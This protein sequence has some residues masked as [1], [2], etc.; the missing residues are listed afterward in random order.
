MVLWR[1]ADGHDL[2][3]VA[4]AACATV[5]AQSLTFYDYGETGRR[6]VTDEVLPREAVERHF[7]RMDSLYLTENP[8]AA[9]GEM[10]LWYELPRRSTSIAV[11]MNNDIVDLYVPIMELGWDRTRFTVEQTYDT[12]P[13]WQ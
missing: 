13:P 1:K 12:L 11:A 7:A 10:V 2:V 8:T 9:E 6:I 3:G 5:C 4:E